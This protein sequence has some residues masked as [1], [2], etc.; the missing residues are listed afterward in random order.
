MHRVLAGFYIAVF[1]SVAAAAQVPFDDTNIT[2]L[3]VNDSM[4]G[5]KPVC[6]LPSCDPG[7]SG[8]PTNTSQT[9]GHVHPSKDG[10]S[11]EVSITGPQ[12]SNALWT[13]HAGAD[14]SATSLS[15]SFWVYLTDKASVA[16]SFEFDQFDFSK[17]TG[18]E[19]M[20]GSQCNQVTHLWQIFDQLHGRWMNTAVKCALTPNQWHDVRWDV[21]RVSGDTDR[22]SGEPCMYYDTLTLDGVVHPVNAAY[23]AGPLPNGWSSAVGFQVQIDIGA[24]GSPVT[25][26]EYLDLADFSAL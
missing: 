15:T 4:T 18:I 5:W 19:F 16:G 8:I 25:V 2:R 9:I 7:G 23:P 12:Y 20:W 24:T 22:C 3:N 21:H 26:D 17:S 1:F 14:D 6:V 13:Y 10:H 11:M